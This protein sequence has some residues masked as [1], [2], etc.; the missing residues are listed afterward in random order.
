MPD[1]LFTDNTTAQN[2]RSGTPASGTIDNTIGIGSDTTNFGGLG[3]VLV[4]NTSAFEIWH[5]L[6]EFTGFSIPGSETVTSALLDIYMPGSSTSALDVAVYR[7]I[8]TWTEGGS[9]W[10]DYDGA[11][12]WNTGGC[13]GS[14]TDKVGTAEDTI[15][16]G[17]A[18]GWYTFDITS[19][20]EGWKAG[21]FNNEGVII[22]RSGATD[23][24]QYLLTSS[25]GTD[26][27]RPQ[28]A[29]TTTAGGGGGDSKPYIIEMINRQ[30]QHLLV[31]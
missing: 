6:F 24:Q 23:A 22:E 26:G 10:Q 3:F 1:Y 16:M 4:Q 28:L 18:A 13:Q 5:A 30:H 31:R 25:E 9:T 14:G 15:T 27:N 19:I 2:G 20:A 17:T 29:V 21:T 8:Q 11:N 7:V 12:A